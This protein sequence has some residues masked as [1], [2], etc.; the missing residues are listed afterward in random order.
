MKILRVSN[1]LRDKDAVF[2]AKPTSNHYCWSPLERSGLETSCVVTIK[3]LKGK[4]AIRKALLE[5]Y[6]NLQNDLYI[7]H[8]AN[9]VLNAF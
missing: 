8:I 2:Q 9:E 7:E 6:D 4:C 3:L 1:L 5:R